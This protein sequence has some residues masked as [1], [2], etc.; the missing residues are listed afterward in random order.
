VGKTG[1]EYR[2]RGVEMIHDVLVRTY[3]MTMAIIRQ[4]SPME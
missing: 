2:Q 1:V 3:N 4:A